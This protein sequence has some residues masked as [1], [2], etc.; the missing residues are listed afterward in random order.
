MSGLLWGWKSAGRKE[1]E[2]QELLMREQMA[3]EER[4]SNT[5]HQ[6][7]VADLKAAGLNP[8]LTATGGSGASTPSVSAPSVPSQRSGFLQGVEQFANLANTAVSATQGIENL[9]TQQA[10]QE[11]FKAQA[12]ESLSKAKLTDEQRTYVSKLFDVDLQNAMTNAKN[13]ETNAQNAKTEKEKVQVEKDKIVA[14]NASSIGKTVLGILGGV[15]LAALPQTRGLL[16]LGG[17][18]ATA[19][20]VAGK[21][22]NNIIQ[23]ISKTGLKF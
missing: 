22:T 3:W 6:R 17:I 15:M 13:A 16:A 4:M 11:L 21:N 23:M 14:N 7:E 19:A 12:I 2:Q 8:I 1:R 18:G 10:Q 5:A 20:S 9:S